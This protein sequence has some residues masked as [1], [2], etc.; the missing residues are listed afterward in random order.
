MFT[1][2]IDT[3]I[4]GSGLSGMYAALITKLSQ[5]IPHA[6]IKLNSPVYQP[7]AGQTTIW[8]GII[9]FAGS[10]TASQHGGYLEGA[11]AGAERAVIQL[12]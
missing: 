11:L 1:K 3:I 10:E 2:D 8:D 9:Q 5:T 6:A 7:P 4:I 12:S